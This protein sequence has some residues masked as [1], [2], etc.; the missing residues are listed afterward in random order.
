[1]IDSQAIIH[2]N[3]KIGQQVSIGPWSII[4]ENV[5]ID[6]GT[7][8]ASH[9]VIKGPTRIGK[10][11]RIFQFSSIGE[12][13]QDKKYRGEPTRLEIGDHNI[14]RE[15]CSIHR[16]TIQDQGITRVGHHN[17]L[18][19]N[20]HIA[21]DVVIGNHCILAND[22]NIAG[23]VHIDDWAIL[24]GATQVHQFCQVGAHSM[25]GGATV[26]TQDLPA[27]IIASGNPVKPRTINIEG[28]KRRQFS[29]QDI[30]SL[31]QAYRFLYRQK[32]SLD[33]AKK[34]I[35][36]ISNQDSNVLNILINSL[37]NASRG[38]IR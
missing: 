33:E 3:A 24:G 5:E 14:I 6:D 7:H 10:H 2:K 16:G 12:D 18:M 23:H 28:L 35:Q 19:I 15:A 32:L 1:M 29:T 34:H 31:R 4:G 20:T 27:Y 38:I 11:N 37:D 21:H 9:V 13:C 30:Q 17:L 8:I 25:T 22:V 36:C 26:L